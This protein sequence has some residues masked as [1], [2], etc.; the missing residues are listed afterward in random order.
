[1]PSNDSTGWETG[2]ARRIL[3]MKIWQAVLLLVMAAMDCLVIVV[4]LAVVLGP[5][6]VNGVTSTASVATPQPAGEPAASITPITML[7]NF[8]T[9]TPFGT[10]AISPTPEDWMTGWTKIS[11]PEVEIWMPDSY[12]AGD[13]HTEAQA[14]LDAL[15]DKGANYNWDY[16]LDQMTNAEPDYVLWGIDSHQ[17]NPEIVTNVAVIY[18]TLARGESISEYAERRTSED[19]AVIEQGDF[20][21]PLYQIVRLVLKATDPE[22]EPIRFVLYSIKDDGSVWNILCVTGT[23]ELEDRLPEFDKMAGSFQAFAAPE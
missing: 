21:H 8:P 9:Y 6:L 15:V 13:P 16:L 18:D 23:D 10:P 11:V 5:L 22:S 3:G 20:L 19:S 7:F 12:A 1:M 14:I 2:A 4:G 17:G